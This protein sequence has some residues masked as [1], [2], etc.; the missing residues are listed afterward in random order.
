[1]SAFAALPSFAA[2]GMVPGFSYHGDKVLARLNSGEEVLRRDDPRHSMNQSRSKG[3]TALQTK[4]MIPS[5][6]LRK[7]DIWLSFMEAD[8]E[9]RKRTVISE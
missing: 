4:V 2:G 6:K 8:K 9:M 5:F 7:G 1:M 3:S